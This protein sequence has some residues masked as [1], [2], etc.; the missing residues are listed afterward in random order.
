[1]RS[2]KLKT[3]V[4]MRLG[5][6]VALLAL[7]IALP[8][9]AAAG[10]AASTRS[11]GGVSHGGTA[12]G[13]S[14]GSHSS[15]SSSSSSSSGGWSDSGRHAVPSGDGGGRS[16]SPS[17]DDGG[18]RGD[19]GRD[20]GRF[21]VPN[22]GGGELRG[23]ESH[24]SH[25]GD[26]DG[27]RP[28]DWG[29]GRGHGGIFIGGWD[30]WYYGYGYGSGYGYGPSWGW[31]WGWRGWWW[32]YGPANVMYDRP[33]SSGYGGGR[34]SGYGALDTDIWPGDAEVYVDGDKVGSVDD[35]DGFPSY[36]WLPRG[37]YDV[38]FYLPGFQ[39]IA[40]QYSIYDG[41]VIDV[42]DRMEHGDA[43]RP[44]N[45]GTK[46][47][48]RRDERE[49]FEGEREAAIRRHDEWRQRQDGDNRSGTAPAPGVSVLPPAA[50]HGAAP[51]NDSGNATRVHLIVAPPDASIY[52]DGN[53]LGTAG[54]LRQ[55]SAGLVVT[56]G[57]HNLEVVR[58]G[59]EPESRD[60]ESKPGE[61]VQLAITLEEE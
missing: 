29:R 25:R 17:R 8:R 9:P 44:E 36:L 59:Y 19:R 18:G 52:L 45:L 20:S 21:A 27:D 7:L 14:G 1:M 26:H 15:G 47:H 49:R 16:G 2:L 24:G 28:G 41:L 33:Y 57:S 3:N 30:P 50:E 58:P 51:D 46:T 42:N 31:G 54:E 34:G 53:F 38:V 48:V 61:D 23:R 13:S 43:V 56:P 39:T 37:T 5:L 22:P 11:D 60:F 32:P 6:T 4:K 12:S 10:R 40:R 55:L 35:F